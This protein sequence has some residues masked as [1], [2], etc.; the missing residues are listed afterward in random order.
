MTGRDRRT[1]GE[2]LL[3]ADHAARDILMDMPDLDPAPMLRTWGE[4]VQTASELWQVLPD[5][6]TPASPSG[7]HAPAGPM[8]QLAVMTAALD[9]SIRQGPWPGPGLTDPRLQGIADTFARA[10]ELIRQHRA[11]GP[12][13]DPAV[14]ADADAARTRVIHT[15]YIAAHGVRLAVSGHVRPLE[16]A[17]T[18]RG[19]RARA[20]GLVVARSVLPRLDAVEQVAGAYVARTHPGALTGEHR[21]PPRGSRVTHALA[22]W[23]VHAHRAIATHPTAG[24]LRLVARTQELIL[25][26]GALILSAAAQ[27]GAIDASQYQSRLEQ[28]LDRA[29]AAWAQA[30]RGWAQFA[31]HGPRPDAPALTM[32]AAEVRAAL[33]EITID[34]STTATP[35]VIAARTDLGVTS[36]TLGIVLST[37][38]DLAHLV[39]DVTLDPD[40]TFAAR[41]VNAAAV[42]ASTTPAGRPVPGLD[43]GAH[44]DIKDLTTNRPI[45]LT[46]LVRAGVA[47]GANALVDATR[48][49]ADSGTWLPSCGATP[50]HREPERRPA[51]PASPPRSRVPVMQGFGC[52]R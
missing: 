39:R 50:P 32:A 31:A 42:A 6:P 25:A 4:V 35:D 44:V 23:D 13:G 37:S 47:R 46:P 10:A 17:A 41:A 12:S 19:S 3:D 18:A 27:T 8:V 40:T 1:V 34:G 26:H 48:A 24:H 30:G 16:R 9:R 14:R 51:P 49:A 5:A 22:A 29:R 45:P 11:A 28:P 38:T 20:S 21:D 15:L 33:R 52:D 36:S 2:L 7:R 43:D